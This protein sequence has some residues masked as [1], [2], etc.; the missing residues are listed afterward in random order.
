MISS[1]GEGISRFWKPVEHQF[2]TFSAESR[3]LVPP[4]WLGDGIWFLPDQSRLRRTSDQADSDRSP[5]GV[6]VPLSGVAC[7]VA[8]TFALD[9]VLRVCQIS[10]RENR[11]FRVQNQSPG[12]DKERADSLRLNHNNVFFFF[13][14]IGMDRGQLFR[15]LYFPFRMPGGR[16]LALKKH[17]SRRLFCVCAL[18]LAQWR[19]P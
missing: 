2:R 8:N 4:C 18:R 17:N 16:Y 5:A 9:I 1:H 14:C 15:V 11:E 10:R 12:I 7:G 19:H 6:S 3:V 13:Y